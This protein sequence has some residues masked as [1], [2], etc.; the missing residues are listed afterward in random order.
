MIDNVIKFASDQFRIRHNGLM[1]VIVTNI[2]IT[3]F[4]FFLGFLLRLVGYDDICKNFESFLCMPSNLNSF[5]EKPWSLVTHMLIQRD[6][7]TIIWHTMLLYTF[8]SIVSEFLGRKHFIP[9]Y[10][11][12]GILGALMVLFF[13]NTFPR[14]KGINVSIY[15]IDSC[16]YAVIAATATVAPNLPLRLFLFG[17][18]RMRYV[19][20]FFIFWAFY[21]LDAGSALGIYQLGGAFGGYLYVK[22]TLLSNFNLFRF[23]KGIFGFKKKSKMFIH[24]KSN[25]QSS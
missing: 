15:G 12:G 23:I 4:S 17:N 2:A 5:I 21:K 6:F 24:N 25:N 9:L 20:C 3:V 11:V 19:L 22:Y 7:W 1:Q 18:V 14:F 10:I 13:Y 16:V 8:G